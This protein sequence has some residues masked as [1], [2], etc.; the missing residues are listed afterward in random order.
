MKE[1]RSARGCPLGGERTLG[2]ASSAVPVV[3]RILTADDTDAFIR[4]RALALRTDPE[5][6]E[7]RPDSDPSL[8]P[9][10]VRGRLEA[11]SLRGKG[12][13]LGAITRQL[14]GIL[15]LSPEEMES[16]R[17]LRLWGFYVVPSM[18]RQ[19]VGRALL[20]T[21]LDLV[22][23]TAEF[24]RLRLRVHA[25][26]Q[27]AIALYRSAG[28]GPVQPDRIVEGSQEFGLDVGPGEGRS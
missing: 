3:L 12:V 28:F 27:A 2:T 24:S 18:R 4:I 14:V 13:V 7:G 23:Q 1:L 5:A 25:S 8:D 10:F 11:P 19:R 26:S 22:R 17:Q 9:A 21:A 16:Q 6:F 15:G 20:N